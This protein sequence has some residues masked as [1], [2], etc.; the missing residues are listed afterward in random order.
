MSKVFKAE[1]GDPLI[2]VRDIYKTYYIGEISVPAVRGVSLT[3]STGDF[4]AIM[5]SSG[6]G[7]STFMHLL[8][9]LDRADAGEYLLGETSVNR[10]NKKEL[11][12]LRNRLIGFVFQS[13][14]LLSRTTVLDNVA[15]PLTY[16]GVKRKQRRKKAAEM[17]E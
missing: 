17:L 16:Q 7:Q 12:T 10:L 6:S 14:N 4:M 3:I 5:G 8:G 2:R 9:C 11:A 1:A 15:L 13:F